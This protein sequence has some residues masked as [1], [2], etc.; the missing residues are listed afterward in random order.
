MA[1]SD[2]I[3]WFPALA[4]VSLSELDPEVVQQGAV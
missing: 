1:F 3:A 2:V 4:S